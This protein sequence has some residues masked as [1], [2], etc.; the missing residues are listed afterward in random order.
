MTR[1]LSARRAAKRAQIADAARELFL[2]QGFAATSMDAVTAAAGVSKQ[3]LYAYFPTK[4]DLLADV[5]S[6]ALEDLAG[7]RPGQP[8]IESVSDLRITLLSFATNL[9]RAILAP[10]FVALMRLILGEAFRIPELW[11][12]VRQALPL[13]MLADTAELVRGAIEN[14]IIKPVSPELAARMLIGPLMTYVALD[15]FLGTEEHPN[16]P[17]QAELEAIVDCFL[18]GIGVER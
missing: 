7:G 17:T 1:G 5:I 14:G 9:L 13:R 16:P 18:A 2:A 12:G 3:T 8:R 15:G 11:L 6:D 10:E 4:A